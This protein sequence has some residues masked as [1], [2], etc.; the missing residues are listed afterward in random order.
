MR[1]WLVWLVAGCGRIG[2]DPG[3]PVRTEIDAPTTFTGPRADPQ[4]LPLANGQ[5]ESATAPAASL[6]AGDSYVDPVTGVRIWKLTDATS[7]ATNLAA[8]S[9]RQS[10]GAQVSAA[11]S[12]TRHTIYVVIDEGAGLGGRYLIDLERGLGIGNARRLGPGGEDSLAFTT[13]P[14]NPQRALIADDQARLHLVDTATGAT[15]DPTPFPLTDVYTLPS[16]SAGG[17]VVVAQSLDTGYLTL[18]TATN[19]EARLVTGADHVPAIDHEGLFITPA[20]S[21]LSQLWRIGDATTTDWKPPTGDFQAA[22]GVSGGFVSVD[23]DTGGDMTFYFSDPTTRTHQVFG[24]YGAYDAV[25]LA[26]QW[27]QTDVPLTAQWV[28]YTT[29]E[30]GFDQGT[31]LDD[32]IGLLQLDGELRLLLHHYGPNNPGYYEQPRASLSPDG[33]MVVFTSTMGTG[34]TDVYAAE[35]PLSP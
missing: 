18:D 23:V 13:D 28:L 14:V 8:R 22:V 27:I 4:Q 24:S 6:A 21:E 5:P 20:I 1:W 25:I 2:F 32:A 3:T 17:R 11:W 26:S 12:D 31:R 19:Q 29:T 33:R 35:V 10:G 30:Q 16:V 15:L 9:E 7:P 34:R